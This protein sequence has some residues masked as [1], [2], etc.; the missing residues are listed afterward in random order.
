MKF[1]N[2]IFFDALQNMR[3]NTI[4]VEICSGPPL[5]A[6]TV[7]I[8]NFKHANR[9]LEQCLWRCPSVLDR[10]CY[11]IICIY[12]VEYFNPILIVIAFLY[13][14]GHKELTPSMVT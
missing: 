1:L 4:T 12:F 13:L 14:V 5:I 9:N 2:I 10:L 3:P 7:T 11:Q 6:A 8:V